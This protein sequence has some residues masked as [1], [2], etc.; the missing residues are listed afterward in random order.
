MIIKYEALFLI[1]MLYLI[2]N[3]IGVLMFNLP[4]QGVSMLFLQQKSDTY[5]FTTGKVQA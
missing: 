4:I 5:D 1:F 3:L 2:L